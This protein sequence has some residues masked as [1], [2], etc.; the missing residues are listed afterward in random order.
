VAKRLTPFLL[1]CAIL[2]GFWVWNSVIVPEQES[3][4][5]GEALK[6]SVDRT[7]ALPYSEPETSTFTF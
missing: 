4:R 2:V 6:V 5:Q 1:L 3:K 7:L